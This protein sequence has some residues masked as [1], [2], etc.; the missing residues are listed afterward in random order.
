MTRHAGEVFREPL[1]NSRFLS[2]A[3]RG[4]STAA[5]TAVVEAQTLARSKRELFG[6][7]TT[8]AYTHFS[9]KRFAIESM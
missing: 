2:A 4:L 8:A 6:E 1:W 7:F 3:G 9:A 5:P